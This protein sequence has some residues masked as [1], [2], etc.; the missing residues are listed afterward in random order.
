MIDTYFDIHF[1]D[2]GMGVAEVPGGKKATTTGTVTLPVALGAVRA[3]YAIYEPAVVDGLIARLPNAGGDLRRAILNALC[4]LDN[5]EAPYLDPKE[6]WG[7]RPDTSGP[8]YKLVRW[9]E[10]EKIEAALKKELD[11]ETEEQARWL[12][13]ERSH[14]TC[15]IRIARAR[16]SR[17]S[18]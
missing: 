3:L 1:L 5:Q 7:T 10:S 6:W 9:Q 13:S 4:R 15:E 14:S 11:S 17:R 2:S 8:V 12:L 16:I 18:R